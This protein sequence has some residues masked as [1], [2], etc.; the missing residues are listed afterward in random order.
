[1]I[2]RKL[3]VEKIYSTNGR[4]FGVTFI[5]RSTGEIRKGNFRL[6]FTVGK[7]IKGTGPRYD[8]DSKNLIPVYRMNGDLSETDGQR[9]TI[10]IEGI[11]SVTIDGTKYDV[12]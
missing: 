11:K 9:R 5:K 4:T 6:G 3:A 12:R 1:M 8:F 10:P 7:G 2:S